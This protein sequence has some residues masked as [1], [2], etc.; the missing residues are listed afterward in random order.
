MSITRKLSA[1]ALSAAL[2]APAFG[3]TAFADDVTIKLWSRA[4]RS[5]PMRSGNIVEAAATLNNFLAAAGSD[6][7]VKVEVHEN[8]AKGFDADALDLMKAFAADKGPDIYVAAHE[9]IGAFVEA[10][11]AA[12][13]EDHIKANPNL[14]ADIIPVLWD[15]VTYKGQRYG[16]PQDSEVRMFFYNKEMMRKAGYDEDAI[17]SLPAR[18]E[19]GEF[20][21]YDLADLAADVKNKGAAKYGFIHRPN[22][23]PDFQMAMASFGIELSD[24]Q[25][26]KLQMSKS[27]FANFAK[28][29]KYSVDKGA[30]PANMTTWSWDSV[31]QAFRGRESFM[32]F[33]G[34]W[35]VPKQLDT[36]NLDKDSY[37]KELGWIHS[38]P[39]EKGGRPANLS[40]PIIYVVSDKSQNKELAS[41]LVA[42]ASQHVPNT[43]HAVS[44][45]HTPI[46]FGQAAMPE[47]VDDGWALRVGTAMLPYSK[48]M[49][50]HPMIGQY[51]AIVYKGIQGVETDRLSPEEAAEFVVEELEA[52][53]GEQVVI[54]D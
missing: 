16:I 10:G 50:N 23:G 49:P 29:L 14:Y 9:W 5:G 8:N 42:L 4:D 2:L 39:E 41:M 24:P 51:N 34:I 45:G 38:P 19:S 33:H 13:M 35:N 7:H 53:L 30:L 54:L 18:V 48:F 47:F 27:K 20:T 12:N 43:K 44:S 28:W 3:Q 22:V 11:Y 25:S 1:V 32:K 17:E 6:K 36:M 37:F 40:H 21:I 26:G 15:S 46:N 52:E 31:H